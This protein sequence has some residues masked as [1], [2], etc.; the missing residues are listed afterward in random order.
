[1][2]GGARLRRAWRWLR[3]LSGDDAY[4]RYRAHPCAHHTPP[5]TRREFYRQEQQRKWNGVSRCC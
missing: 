2:S 3:Q 5:L 1:M 4:E